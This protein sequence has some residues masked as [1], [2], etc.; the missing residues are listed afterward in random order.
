MKDLRKSENLERKFVLITKEK[1]K[2][3]DAS[4]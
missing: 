4:V 2:E 1:T 3:V